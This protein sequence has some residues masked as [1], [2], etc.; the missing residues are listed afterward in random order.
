MPMSRQKPARPSRFWT[1]AVTVVVAVGVVALLGVT[2]GLVPLGVSPSAHS[3]PVTVTPPS[4]PVTTTVTPRPGQRPRSRLRVVALGD[5][6]TAGS[7]C[8]CDAFP[9]VYA[10]L[11]S[12][13]QHRPVQVENLGVA[14]LGSAGMLSQLDQTSTAR[15]VAAADVVLVTIGANDFSDHKSDV[16]QDVCTRPGNGDCVSD[17]LDAM[18]NRVSAALARIRRLR[19][20]PPGQVLVTGYWNVFEDGKVAR[21]S[22]SSAGVAATVDLTVRANA[23]LRRAADANGATYVD[24]LGPFSRSARDITQLL[25]GDGDHP[26]A[27]GHQ[28]I[29]RTLLAA[30]PRPV[31]SAAGT[32]TT[33]P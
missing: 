2:T 11:L 22:Y 9:V 23:E 12:H 15:D 8:G 5:S 7:A 21:Q 28:L 33:A 16:T 4:A 30:G 13:Q 25:A 14:G 6:V 20:G 31:S 29:A 10:R 19:S 1:V 32:A 18:R 17:E 26:D 24:L 27:R 3:R